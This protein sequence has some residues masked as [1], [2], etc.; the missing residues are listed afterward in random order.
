MTTTGDEAEELD[1][2]LLGTQAHADA[3]PDTLVRL[4]GELDVRCPI[5]ARV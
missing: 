4:V 1:A 5:A 3:A 2:E